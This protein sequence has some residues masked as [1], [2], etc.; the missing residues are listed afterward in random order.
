[1]ALVTVSELEDAMGGVDFN[2]TQIANA[3]YLIN[4]VSTYI[5]S[6]T[7][8]KFSPVTDFTFRAKSDDSGEIVAPVFPVTDVSNFHDFVTDLD[9]SYPRWDGMD[10]FYGLFSKQVVDITVSYGYDTCPDD[11]KNVVLEACKRGMSVT[12]TS[13]I[14]KTVGDV[15]YQYGDMLVFPQADQDII[16]SYEQKIRTFT[17]EDRGAG[18]QDS[19]L[20]Q[21]LPWANGPDM[22]YDCD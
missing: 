2:D 22:P 12:S 7:N 14:M 1:M 18:R 17:L 11:L 3:N 16:D 5:E 8:T 10:L 6:V 15:I 19:L 9:I 21:W 13:L 20:T 4:R